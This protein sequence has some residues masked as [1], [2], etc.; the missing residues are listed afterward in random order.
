M[1]DIEVR[2]LAKADIF[3]MISL[4]RTEPEGLFTYYNDGYKCSKEEITDILKSVL[5]RINNE[6]IENIKPNNKN[7]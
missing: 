7:K 2:D 4:L 6:E 3:N 5:R 1:T